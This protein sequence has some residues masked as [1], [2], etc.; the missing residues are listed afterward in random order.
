MADL[1]RLKKKEEEI[2]ASLR[3]WATFSGVLSP[4]EQL[5]FTLSVQ[6]A[7]VVRSSGDFYRMPV[8]EFFNEERIKQAGK[9][10]VIYQTKIFHAWRYI[11]FRGT[12][13]L[14]SEVLR[15]EEFQIAMKDA[16]R[17]RWRYVGPKTIE[18]IKAVLDHYG[19]MY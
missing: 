5:V 2:K 6:K 1:K 19:V 7:D 16:K 3:D 14:L 9:N 8:S 18:V 17:S 15:V 4:G 11:G 10:P 13:P 12:S